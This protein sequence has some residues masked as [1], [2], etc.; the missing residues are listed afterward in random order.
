MW[1]NEKREILS[2]GNDVWGWTG[3][4]AKRKEKEWKTVSPWMAV[5]T[6]MLQQKHLL[7][8]ESEVTKWSQSV[9]VR[10]GGGVY[11][12][13]LDSTVTCFGGHWKFDVSNYDNEK[14]YL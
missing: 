8:L 3:T 14:P 1:Q 10:F 5:V 2:P 12:F 7:K 9:S 4:F 13:L 11:M 6:T